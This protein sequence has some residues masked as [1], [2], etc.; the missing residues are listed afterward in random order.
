MQYIY[1]VYG[2]NPSHSVM[3]QS[4]ATASGCATNMISIYGMTV[5]STNLQ[6]D[7]KT[8]QVQYTI[9]MED[10]ESQGYSSGQEAYDTVTSTMQAALADGTFTQT[11]QATAAAQ[12]NTDYLYSSSNFVSYD[13]ANVENVPVSSDNKD[14][15]LNIG[16]LCGIAAAVVLLGLGVG[17]AYWKCCRKTSTSSVVEMPPRT[18]MAAPPA[19]ADADASAPEVEV[20]VEGESVNPLAE[21][22]NHA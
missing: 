1:T 12:G 9:T 19:G 16:M 4:V 13:E 22:A 20:E 15:G 7:T 6:T 2:S 8:Y 17:I 21:A 14:D 18:S 5:V 3:Q 11:L 10:V